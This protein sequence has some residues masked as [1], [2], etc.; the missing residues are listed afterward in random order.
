ME[1]ESGARRVITASEISARV[2]ELAPEFLQGMASGDIANV[3]QAATLRRIPVRSIIAMQG[4][5]ADELFLIVQG[6]AR[7]F[8]TTSRGEKVLLMRIPAGDPSGGR[9]LLVRPTEYMVSTEAVTECTALVWGRNSI[10]SLTKQYPILLEN[11]LMIA[12]EYFGV[13]RDMLV[14]A[15][16]HTASERIAQVLTSLSRE[17]GRKGFEGTVIDISNEELANEANVTIFTVS[18]MLGEWQK[19]GLV[20]KRRGQIVVRSPE[21]LVRIEA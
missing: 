7:T 2:S 13:L 11:A 14:A 8:T 19:K 4:H 16:H 12:S 21:E 1:T 17:V 6:R 18:R 20:V 5:P 10:L 9:A 15:S 3:L